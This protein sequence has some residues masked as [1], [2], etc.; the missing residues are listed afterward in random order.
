MFKKLIVVDGKGHLLGRLASYIAKTLLSGTNITTQDKELLSS[1]VKGSTLPA[2]S[3]ETKSNTQSSSEKDY[4]LTPEEDLYITEHLHA[5]SGEQS[6]ACFPTKPQE[7]PL[8]WA[9]LK[10][11][12]EF[13]HPMTPKKDKSFLMP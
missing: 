10:S 13:P 8:P 1:D 5:S 2:P 11:S 6:E 3:L 12:K 7:E 9:D 4:L